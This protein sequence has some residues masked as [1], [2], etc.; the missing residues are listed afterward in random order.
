VNL[1]EKLKAL[2][3]E[4]EELRKKDAAD[5]T[6]EDVARI[7]AL[8][9][10]I[11]DTESKIKAQDDAAAALKAAFAA[12]EQRPGDEPEPPAAR[13]KARGEAAKS[14]GDAFVESDALK[15]FREQH[16]NGVAKG[17]PINVEARRFAS[18]AA[19]VRAIKAPLNTID[20][21]DTAPTRLPGIE[22]VTY[23]RPNTLL[24]LI[25]IGTTAAAWLQYR[26]LI[27]VLNNAAIVPEAQTNNTA[28]NLKPISGLTTKTADAKAHTYADGIEATTQELN[29][30]G[31]LSSLIN[32]I[33]A[34]NLRDEIERVVLAGDEDDEE[35]NGILN[36]TGVLQQAFATD[37][38]TTIRKGKTLL[39]ESSSTVA[40][41][42]LVN[43]EDAEKLDLLKDGNQRYYGNGP[44]GVGPET[45]WGVP[46]IESSAIPAGQALMGDFRAV[47]FLVYE[48]LSVLAFNQHKDYAQRNLVY[49]RAELRGLQMIRQPAKLA[50][51]D[52]A[53]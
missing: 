45:V 48:A 19:S 17:N 10:E 26:Q 18:K 31:A 53:A 49:I 25:T 38:V 8:T 29:D 4:A 3:A 52:L 23:R 24:D 35:P 39:R 9:A 2:L 6:E 51:L 46:R 33:L 13:T 27:A 7:P 43:P 20:N 22:D 1:K 15:A 11:A 47:Q 40:Q 14:L 30:D 28:A 21:G 32:G 50:L 41:A 16:P 42:I 37:M 44:F 5:L 36:T 12:D 34:Q